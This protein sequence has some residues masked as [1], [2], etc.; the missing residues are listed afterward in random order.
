MSPLVAFNMG[1]SHIPL[2]KHCANNIA[3]QCIGAIYY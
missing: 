3:E 1:I 2:M